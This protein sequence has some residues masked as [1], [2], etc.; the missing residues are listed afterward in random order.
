MITVPAARAV[1]DSSGGCG[2]NGGG[3]KYSSSSDCVGYWWQCCG[4]VQYG[5]GSCV[6]NRDVSVRDGRVG[7]SDIAGFS[8][9][10]SSEANLLFIKLVV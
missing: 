5:V 10:E 4:G 7:S 6:S 2:D 3:S 1:F 8:G 9:G